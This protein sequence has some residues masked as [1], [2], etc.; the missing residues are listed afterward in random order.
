MINPL[1][2]NAINFQAVPDLVR[3]YL[4]DLRNLHIREIQRSHLGQAIVMFHCV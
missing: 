3:E 1:P 2:V 4:V